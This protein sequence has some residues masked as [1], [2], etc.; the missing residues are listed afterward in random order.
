MY[1]KLPQEIV[2]TF[3]YQGCIASLDLNG[4]AANPMRKALVPSEHVTEGCEGKK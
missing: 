4:E 1:G 2:S 3:G